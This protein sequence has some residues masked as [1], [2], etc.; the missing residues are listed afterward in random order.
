LSGEPSIL[1]IVGTIDIPTCIALRRP[2]RE[3]ALER[4]SLPAPCTVPNYYQSHFPS[5]VPLRSRSRDP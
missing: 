1:S 5:K 2:G 3:L 4:H